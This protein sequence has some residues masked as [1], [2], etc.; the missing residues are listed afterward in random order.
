VGQ[1]R[2]SIDPPG[3]KRRVAQVDHLSPFRNCD[4]RSDRLDRFARHEHH[5]VVDHRVGL[6]VKHAGRPQDDRLGGL[7][8]ACIQQDECIDG[9][10]VHHEVAPVVGRSREQL[11]RLLAVGCYLTCAADAQSPLTVTPPAPLRN[12]GPRLQS[13]P[14]QMRRSGDGETE[15]GDFGLDRMARRDLLGGDLQGHSWQRLRLTA[16]TC[17]F[18]SRSRH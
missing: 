14:D 3:T 4:V 16:A 11:P 17:R 12:G 2:V 18:R 8:T 1:V 7:G 10:Q 6:A 13:G 9:R 5:A 15:A